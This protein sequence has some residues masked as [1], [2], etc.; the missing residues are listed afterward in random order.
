MTLPCK[1]GAIT[2]PTPQR[3]GDLG[4]LFQ[5]QRQVGPAPASPPTYITLQ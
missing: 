4:W 1:S 5:D 3:L 2:S